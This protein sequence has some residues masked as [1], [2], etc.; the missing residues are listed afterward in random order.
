[1][2][3]ALEE[4]S[5][6]SLQ[7]SDGPAVIAFL[8]EC[9]YSADP[10]F[11]RW[12]N[13]DSPE[14]PAWVELAVAQERVV[15]HYGVLPRTLQINGRRV[16]AGLAIHA[17]VHPQFRGLSI[18]RGL[19]DRTLDRCRQADLP[20]IYGYPR[21]EVW[22]MYWKL[23]GWKLMGE[24][25]TLELPL[26]G[27]RLL[28][29]GG[30]SGIRFLPRASFDEAYDRFPHGNLLKNL[31]HVVKDRAALRWR[32]EVHPR[33]SYELAESRDAA[34]GVRGYLV[35]KRYE[36]EGKRYGH[37]VEADAAEGE[38]RV[39]SELLTET[40]E[41]FRQEGIDVASCWMLRNSPFYPSLQGLG[42]RP[43]GFSTPVGYGPM[44]PAVSEDSLALDC[45]HMVMGDSDAF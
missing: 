28:T 22:L 39:F 15:G 1:M 41:R 9:G 37:L 21:R 12:I 13:R 31:N 38:T 44:A 30:R 10:S 19:W 36:K 35:L 34:G 17:A 25:V 18:L 14:G 42:F 26:E 6:R 16:R 5:Y 3:L 20:F 43:V 7:E 29:G 23:F 40:L 27:T 45:W 24:L 33:A 8:K 11:W 2:S 4:I 32:Y